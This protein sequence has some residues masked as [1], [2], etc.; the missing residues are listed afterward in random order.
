M[1]TNMPTDFPFPPVRDAVILCVAVAGFIAYG[2]YWVRR[3]FKR[4]R[5]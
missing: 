1:G 5:S 2:V 3:I 4:G